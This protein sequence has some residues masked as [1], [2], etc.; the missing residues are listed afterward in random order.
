MRGLGMLG[1][2]Y[3][4]VP[5]FISNQQSNKR[6]IL[7]SLSPKPKLI[8]FFIDCYNKIIQKSIASPHGAMQLLPLVLLM[9][10]A[11]TTFFIVA[12]IQTQRTGELR[13]FAAYNNTV[14]STPKPIKT[15]IP[16]QQPLT[17]TGCKQ[18]CQGSVSCENAC[19]AP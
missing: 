3:F 19:K 9:V 1:T 2:F 5:E 11:A 16:S 14:V 10:F 18:L 4:V 12:R 6:E 8:Q 13:Q 15:P 17:L 7:N